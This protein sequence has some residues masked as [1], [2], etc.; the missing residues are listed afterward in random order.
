MVDSIQNSKVFMMVAA[1]KALDYKKRNP[2]A[3]SNEIIQHI[4]KDVDALGH[5]KISAIA[6]A[7]RAIKYKDQNPKVPDKDIMQ[8]IMDEAVEI[9]ETLE[10][11]KKHY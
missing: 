10:E 3:H 6:A 9:L 4:V 11:Y 1:G 5:V 7:D 2:D 8:R